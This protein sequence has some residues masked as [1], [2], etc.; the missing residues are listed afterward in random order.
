MN[1]GLFPKRK[2][3][4]FV[5]ILFIFSILI[6]SAAQTAFGEGPSGGGS[7]GGGAGGEGSG[8]EGSGGEGSGGEGS[9]GEGS[10][11]EGSGGEGSGGEGSGGEGSGGEGGGSGEGNQNGGNEGESNTWRHRYRNEINQSIENGSLVMEATFQIRNRHMVHE[12]NHYQLGMELELDEATKKRIRVRVRAEFKE[13]K[14]IV[15]NVGHNVLNFGELGECNAYFDGKKMQ[16]GTLGE[17]LNE[18]GTQ[19]KYTAAF[20]NG[21][22]QFLVYIPHFSEHTI[23]IESLV[24]LTQ[25]ELFT[26]TNLV[27]AGLSILTLIGISLHIY[28]IG[29]ARN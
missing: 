15:L 6:A 12:N 18:N 17:V 16:Q 14:L 1:K 11:G 28:K 21:G 9:G 7:G 8:G 5:L 23:E 4:R 27:V 20:G 13:G 19:A 22:A 3:L 2:G 24:E 10:G 26:Q 25:K 29:K